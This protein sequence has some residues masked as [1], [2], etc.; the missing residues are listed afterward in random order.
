MAS[1]DNDDVRRLL[2]QHLA[3]LWRFAIVLSR[4]RDTAEDLVQATCLR[5]LERAAQFEPG[6]RLDRWLFS[7]LHS[8]WVN[9]RRARKIR[10]GAGHVDA[11]IALSFDGS[12]TIETNILAAQ[13]LSAIGRLP[14]GQRETVLLV[15]AEGFSYRD[16]A[17]FL[18]VPIGTVM[19]RLA[20]ARERLA[21]L[22]D[23]NGKGDGRD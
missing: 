16:A 13:L 3:A 11:A 23:E 2:R 15:Y 17:A 20:A 1:R 18:G 10:D 12:R 8:I 21:E 6:S 9:E 4:S 14:E 5:A 19:S 7:I 22:K